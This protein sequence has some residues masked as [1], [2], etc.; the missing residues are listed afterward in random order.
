LK[1][2]CRIY[3][4]AGT[5]VDRQ[6]IA[7]SENALV[8][9]EVVADTFQIHSGEDAGKTIQ[10]VIVGGREFPDSSFGHSKKQV[11]GELLEIGA[12]FVSS[13]P[14]E[15]NRSADIFVCVVNDGRRKRGQKCPR[16]DEA[17]NSPAQRRTRL[18]L[19]WQGAAA[20][21]LLCARR[22]I[23]IQNFSS[24]RKRRGA[25]LPAAVHDGWDWQRCGGI[26]E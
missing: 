4:H 2:T 7:E 1:I 16:S 20:T 15:V 12:W 10:K 9:R 3:P 13:Q 11:E 8:F 23:L 5:E 22:S 14:S 24:G 19:R 18:G 25:P 17:F 26:Y 21:P 6:S